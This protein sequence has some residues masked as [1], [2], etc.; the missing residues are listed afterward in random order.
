[1]F[2]YT[3]PATGWQMS[4]VQM[5]ASSQMTLLVS[6]TQPS[7]GRHESIVQGFRSSHR[8]MPIPSHSPSLQVSVDVHWFPSSHSP[9]SLAGSSTQAPVSGRQT[10]PM[11]GSSGDGQ[12][13]LV[14]SSMAQNPSGQCRVPL[15]RFPSSFSRHSK[16]SAQGQWFSSP[17]QVPSTHESGSVQGFPSSQGTS[18]FVKRHPRVSSQWSDVQS[19]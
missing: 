15:Q 17:V 8:R 11:Q 3:Q 6:N 4:L 12:S 18:M 1:M 10:V 14:A 9:P 5:F 13:I 2:S 19:L 7:S 16:S